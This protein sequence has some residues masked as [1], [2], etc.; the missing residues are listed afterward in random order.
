MCRSELKQNKLD[1]DSRIDS[2][3]KQIQEQNS[4]IAEVSARVWCGSFTWRITNFE[5]LFQQAKNQELLA[6]H[7]QPFYT[8]VPGRGLTLILLSSFWVWVFSFSKYV[9]NKII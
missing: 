9:C 7:S 2:L 6:I 8:A 5:H 1:I 4:L 3:G